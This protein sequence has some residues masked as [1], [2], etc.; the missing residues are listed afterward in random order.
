M[1]RL[2]R[3]SE[4]MTKNSEDIH[5]I[6]TRTLSVTSKIIYLQTWLKIHS[7]LRW[8]RDVHLGMRGFPAPCELEMTMNFEGRFNK[9][10]Q[11]FNRGK[12][13]LQPL[14]RVWYQLE[15][16][17]LQINRIH[18]FCILTPL[19]CPEAIFPTSSALKTLIGSFSIRTKCSKMKNLHVWH[20]K[21]EYSSCW[22]LTAGMNISGRFIESI[23]KWYI[24]ILSLK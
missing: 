24:C 1:P 6:S 9:V 7:I 2:S 17:A 3:S 8:K 15:I 5:R 18:V 16:K 10:Y 19:N 13:P 4:S 22:T 12:T 21:I 14:V 11:F 23:Y 20:Y